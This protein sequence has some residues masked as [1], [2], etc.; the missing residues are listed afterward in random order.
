MARIQK[1]MASEEVRA[2]LQ[3]SFVLADAL[4]INGTPSYVIGSEIMVGAVGLATL[5]ERINTARCAKPMC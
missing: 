4:G 5:K 1:D 2:T 3:E